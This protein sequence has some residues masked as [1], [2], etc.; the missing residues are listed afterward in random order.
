MEVV[1]IG[2]VL[3]LSKVVKVP[4]PSVATLVEPL[5]EIDMFAKT[6]AQSCLL[7]IYSGPK[8]TAVSRPKNGSQRQLLAE[9][10][11]WSANTRTTGCLI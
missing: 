10:G 2:S 5:F 7:A 8:I 4:G 6:T 9:L 1:N 3:I 11:A